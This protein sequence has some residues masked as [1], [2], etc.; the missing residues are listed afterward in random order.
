MSERIGIFG[1][2]FDPVHH[3][4]L[5]LAQ[6]ALEQLQLDR[7]IFVPAGINP[8]KLESGPQASNAHRLKML[9]LAT[10]DEPRFQVDPLELDR[11]G[12]SFTVDSVETF[13]RRWPDAL[14][15]L[16][17]GEDNL[18]KLHTW[19]RFEELR[20]WVTFISFGRATASPAPADTPSPT[21]TELH[22]ERQINISSTEIRL[23]IAQG[24]SIRYL[25]PEPVRL[26]IHSHVLYQSPDQRTAGISLR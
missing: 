14:F 12:P 22:L 10:Q 1:G 24:L 9:Q 25:V 6:D 19:N 16:L 26:L 13:R 17:L 15:F 3:G 18:P 2:S 8:H 5:I 23:R 7:L 4:H 21:S 20:R 11:E